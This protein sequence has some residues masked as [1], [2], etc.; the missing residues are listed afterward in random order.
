MRMSDSAKM[1]MRSKII[2]FW[3]KLIGRRNWEVS[4]R[5]L[6]RK[7]STLWTHRTLMK[8]IRRSCETAPMTRSAMNWSIAVSPFI[9]ASSSSHLDA[10]STTKPIIKLHW[11]AMRTIRQM[12]STFD[13]RFSFLLLYPF[14]N[15]ISPTVCFWMKLFS[16]T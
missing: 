1:S 2:R 12:Q 5:L 6:S 16:Y 13:C 11:M 10:F 4:R 7:L 15:A 8:L 3:S 14:F 9:T